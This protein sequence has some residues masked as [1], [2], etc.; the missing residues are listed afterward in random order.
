M[1]NNNNIKCIKNCNEKAK[2]KKSGIEQYKDYKKL[3]LISSPIHKYKTGRTDSFV[4]TAGW[5]FIQN[6]MSSSS[7][8]STS[9]A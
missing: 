3:N 7:G 4:Y 8:S 9:P 5:V 1:N 2:N 6:G